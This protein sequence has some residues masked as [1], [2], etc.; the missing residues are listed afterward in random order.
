MTTGEMKLAWLIRPGSLTWLLCVCRVE[1]N[2]NVAVRIIDVLIVS[3][4]V[5]KHDLINYIY[6][7][8]IYIIIMILK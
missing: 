2:M 3:P 7:I 8:Y 6:I 4:P 5:A 1:V